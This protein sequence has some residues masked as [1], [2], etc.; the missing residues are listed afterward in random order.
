VYD[1]YPESTKPENQAKILRRGLDLEA[2]NPIDGLSSRW[3]PVKGTW[4]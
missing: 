4:K 3:D 2:W 1:D